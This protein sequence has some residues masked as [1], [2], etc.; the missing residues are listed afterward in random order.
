[1]LNLIY[2][3]V[4]LLNLIVSHKQKKSNNMLILTVAFIMILWVGNTDGPDIYNYINNYTIANHGLISGTNQFLYYWSMRFFNQ[5]GLTFFQ[6]RFVINIIGIGII[7][8]T[9]QNIGTNVHLVVVLYLLQ[10]VFLDGIQIRNF[11]AVPFLLMGLLCLLKQVKHW[12]ILFVLFIVI[13]SQFHVSFLVYLVFLLLPTWNYKRSRMLKIHG[14]VGLVLTASI[15]RFRNQ[16]SS[17]VAALNVI[18]TGRAIN[19]SSASTNMGALIPITL[20]LFGVYITLYVYKRMERTS[21]VYTEKPE[22]V[23]DTGVCKYIYWLNL[24]A[25][26]LLP[27]SIIQLTFYRLVRN[28]LLI[29][30]SSIGIGKKYFKGTNL[31]ILTFFYLGSWMITEFVLLNTFDNIVIPF[32]ESNMFFG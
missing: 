28:I 31:T 29:N 20:Q 8:F 4:L 26:Y 24:L 1:M 9:L 15:F 14:L 32:F 10:L 19:Y 21:S 27:F 16:L 25:C 5:L 13:A 11:S 7:L 18:D 3:V 30:Y 22:L 2:G 17:I 6:Y 12:R 23:R